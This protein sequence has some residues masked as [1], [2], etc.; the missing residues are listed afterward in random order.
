MKRNVEQTDRR[1]ITCH[2]ISLYAIKGKENIFNNNTLHAASICYIEFIIGII[3][4]GFALLY[5]K[6]HL[7]ILVATA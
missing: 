4:F 2:C 3:L 5:F 6:N 7:M 1:W